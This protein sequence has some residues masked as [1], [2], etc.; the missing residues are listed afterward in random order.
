MS[1]VFIFQEDCT[2]EKIYNIFNSL[3]DYIKSRKSISLDFSNIT[4][5]DITFLQLI[6]SLHFY[7]KNNKI[8]LQKQNNLPEAIKELSINTGFIFTIKNCQLSDTCPFN[9]LIKGNLE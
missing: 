6:C 9:E 1:D 3:S 2:F 7:S 5:L 8:Q 4:S